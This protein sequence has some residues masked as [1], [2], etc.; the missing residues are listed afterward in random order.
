MMDRRIRLRGMWMTAAFLPAVACYE[1]A[2]LPAAAPPIGET[3]A[4]D[5][6]DQGRVALA[7]RFGP[8][9]AR[10]EGKIARADTSV[11]VVNVFSVAHLN[12][13]KAMWSGETTSL[14]RSYLG[15][16]SGRQFSRSRTAIVAV[17]VA[18][19]VAAFIVSRNLSG[20][21]AGSPSDPTQHPP[22]STRIPAAPRP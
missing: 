9:V 4:F 17:A 10:I 21:F 1:Y 6:T 8:G 16:V 14:Q 7:D 5:I 18:G 22:V 12:G 15:T 3:V 20:S 19:V 2:P 13:D 11:Y